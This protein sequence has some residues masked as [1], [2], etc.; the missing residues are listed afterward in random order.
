MA[1]VRTLLVMVVLAVMSTVL[2]WV[3]FLNGGEIHAYFA[4]SLAFVA[5]VRTYEIERG[6][7]ER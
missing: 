4:I 1:L 6:G 2:C 7:K 5:L 3:G